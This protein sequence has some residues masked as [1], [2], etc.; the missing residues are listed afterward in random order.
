MGLTD[1]KNKKGV[2]FVACDHPNVGIFSVGVD[3]KRT[4]KKMFKYPSDDVINQVNREFVDCFTSKKDGEIKYVRHGGTYYEAMLLPCGHCI[5]CRLEYSRQWA[6]RCTLEALQHECNYFVTLTYDDNHLPTNPYKLCFD[7]STGLVTHD[8]HS[9]PLV[10]RDLQ[11]FIKRLRKHF[12]DKYGHIG[13]RFF[14]CGEY[15]GKTGRPHYH[16]IL[17]NCPIPD[18]KLYKRNFQGKPLYNSDMLD[19]LWNV[20]YSVIAE[21]CFDT[22]AYVARYIMKK[23]TGDNKVIYDQLDLVPEFTRMSRKPGVGRT[24]YDENKDKIYT[25]DSVTILGADGKALTPCP[26]KYF[27][28]LYGE[29]NPDGLLNIKQERSVVNAFT[30]RSR[31]YQTGLSKAT[32]LSREALERDR[33]IIALKRTV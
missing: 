28:K 24:F 7:D 26:P 6:M 4:L 16:I 21:C 30:E 10:P 20:G 33:L 23:Q 11:L 2:I 9:H 27:D 32:S 22:C 14:A 8:G 25:Y 15:G 5:G 31:E 3:G 29:E 18:L 1:T 13:I 19:K 12:E 17:F